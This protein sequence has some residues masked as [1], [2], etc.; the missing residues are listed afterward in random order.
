MATGNTRTNVL[1]TL[2]VLFTIG[3]ASRILPHAFAA[4]EN[5]VPAEHDEGAPGAGD[6]MSTSYDLDSFGEDTPGRVCFTG[7]AAAAL[8]KDQEAID[9][10]AE[11]IQEQELELQ[12]RKIDLD[13]RAQELQALQATLEDRW[14]QMSA[15]A[16]QDVEHLAQMYATMKADQAAPIFDQMD[17]GFAA[18]FLRLMPSDQAGGILA[19]MDTSKAYVVSVKLAS[20]NDDIRAAQD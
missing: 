10:R 15:E 18:G 9:R 20:L 12:A 6:L 8:E 4:A 11:A 16:D 5:T 7:E 2:G 19:S 14:R 17:P 1:I 3:G 13:R